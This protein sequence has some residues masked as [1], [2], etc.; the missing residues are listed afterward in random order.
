MTKNLWLAADV[1]QLMRLRDVDGLSFPQIS[2]LFPGRTRKDCANKYYLEQAKQ[3]N[4]AAVRTPVY[5][6]SRS[7]I[8]A[9]LQAPGRLVEHETLTAAFF[10]DPLP[11]RSALDQRSRETT[12]ITLATGPMR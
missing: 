4:T 1:T 3:N 9:A 12:G 8:V 10:G 7:E 11:G 2:E 6:R 5:R